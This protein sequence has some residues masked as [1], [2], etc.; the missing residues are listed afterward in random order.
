MAKRSDNLV[1]LEIDSRGV[2]AAEVAVDG[3]ISVRRAATCA[4]D[5]G[6]VRDGEISDVEGLA[7][8]LRALWK[9]NKGLSKRIRVGL[10]SQKIVVRVMELPPLADPKELDT[11]VRFH[12]QDHVPMALDQAVLD[13]QPLDVVD[14]GAGPRQRVLLVAAR[15]EMVDRMLAAVRGAGLRPE[16]IDLSAFAMIRALYRPDVSD[17][18]AVL[19]LS[20]GGLTNMA[21]AQGPMC[22]YTR[23]SSR[24]IEGVAIE[25]AER[26]G[27][28]L[29][30]A[31]GWLEHVGLEH[32]VELVEGDPEIIVAARQA[33]LEG[34]RR[35][36]AEIHSNLD[37]HRTMDGGVP[38]RSAVLTGP[39]ASI[40][41]FAAALSAHLGLPVETGKVRGTSDG[42]EPERA[43]IA[44]GLAVAE[45]PA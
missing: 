25:L 4:L 28:T 16:G 30:H 45:V 15:R 36:A 44:A 39:A 29:E 27:L 24:G 5:D 14:T 7:N 40:P 35:I 34:G 19:Y 22:L 42:L 37:F 23:T 11:A 20:I 6:I 2:T 3:H 31:R 32:P 38:V 13:F 8:A 12:A 17:D 18:G 10:A 41:G 9:A 43:A 1:G 21:V 26:R 33:L